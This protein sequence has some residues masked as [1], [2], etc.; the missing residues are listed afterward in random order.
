S[1]L[2][3]GGGMDPA[4]GNWGWEHQSWSDRIHAAGLTSWR[5]AD[6]VGSD[7]LFYSMDQHVEVESTATDEAR[8]FS[9]GPGLELRMA[10]RNSPEFIPFR[11][12]DDVVLTTMLCAQNDPQRG[13][14]LPARA[15]E[16]RALHDSLKHDGRFVVLTTGLQGE[17]P[18]AELVVVEQSI[19]P[20]FERWLQT[21]KWL[22]A[23]PQVGRVWCVDA[24]DVQ[25]TR[26]PFP[27]MEPGR[28][29][30]GYEP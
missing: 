9:A 4:F 5:Y 25:M 14:R 23:N 12:L 27:E 2:D 24:T 13:T 15:Q 22:R 20:Y 11:Q 16:V 1:V 28:L 6:V 7:K 18:K 30:F 29:Y 17:L 19:N 26:D 8:R 3:V 21:Y 10:S